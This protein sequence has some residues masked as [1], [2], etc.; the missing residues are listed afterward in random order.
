MREIRSSG[1]VEG[2]L[3]DGH[4]YSD[5]ELDRSRATLTPYVVCAAMRKNSWSREKR[6]WRQ[7]AD[8]RPVGLRRVR[9]PHG[10]LSFEV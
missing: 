10:H 9:R 5:S 1:S 6:L 2:V 8:V 4:L 7:D 3:G